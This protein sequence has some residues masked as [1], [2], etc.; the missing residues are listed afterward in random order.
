[1]LSG[2]LPV[3]QNVLIH[4]DEHQIPFIEADND[5]DLAVALGAVHAHL[6]LG[7]MELLRRLA[8]GRIAEVVGPLGVEIDRSLRLFDFGRA[9]PEIIARLAEP[10]WRWAESFLRGVNHQAARA[11]LGEEF[12][13]L[14]IA[15]TPWTLE[16]LFTAGRLAAADVSWLVWSRLLRARRRLTPEQWAA[17]WP[18]LVGTGTA[19]ARPVGTEAALNAATRAGS[20]AAAVAARRS[21]SGAAL[22]AADPH[23]SVTLPNIWIAAG[24]RSPGLNAV[25][26]M[27]TGFPILAIGR[28]PWLAWGGTNL[29]AA[30]SELFDARGLPMTEREERIN[31]RGGR[32]RRVRLRESTLGP[33]V[34]D[35]ALLRNPSPLAL[36]WM[37]HAPSD[38]IGAMLGVMRARSAEEF[39]A[40]LANFSVPAQNM[41]HAGRDGRVGHLLAAHLPRRPLAH[42]EDLVSHPTSAAPW[43]EPARTA[44]M[45]HWIDPPEGFVA[46][47]NNRPPPG[48][49]PVGFFFSPPDRVERMRALLGGTKIITRGD[50]EALQRDVAG[51]GSLAVRDALLARMSPSEFA[52]PV[53]QVL[54]E[55]DGFYGARSTGALAYEV[56]IAALARRLGTPQRL[57]SLS[58]VWT[59]RA[60]IAQEIVGAPDA[61]F[62]AALRFA[63]R[64][65]ERALRRLGTWSGA[66][67]MLLHHHLA[68]LPL[69]GRR[70]RFGDVPAEGGNDTLNK[71]GHRMSMG[72]HSVST[73]ASARFIADMS[74]PDANRVV[75]LGGQ[76]GWVGSDT[77]LDQVPLWQA[78]KYID[79]PLQAETARH[80]PHHTAHPPLPKG[81]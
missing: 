26:L 81:A 41:L 12:R 57:A 37:G 10:T 69:L 48:A 68:G 66:H 77:F 27:P 56:L 73:G 70:Y 5:D 9:V 20:N 80:W 72:R 53:A 47:A 76:D 15:W 40:A 74:D 75:L 29:H 58:A 3:R 63:F 54:A 65:A 52:H 34:S 4:W 33:I 46:S 14:K 24:F 36:R 61:A 49:L 13:L 19:E 28:N 2:P 78:G 8:T 39:R 50:L 30:S 21:Q 25:G 35:G 51:T 64:R 62:R 45:P 22:F 60:M 43:D 38:E 17:L 67:R 79:L 18:A 31:V 44:E 11:P 1:M 71:T 16:D 6:R 59:G 7:Q 55:W 23:L 32:T 42:P